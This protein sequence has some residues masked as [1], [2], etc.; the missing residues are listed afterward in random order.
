MIVSKA[1]SALRKGGNPIRGEPG[2]AS[3]LTLTNPDGWGLGSSD[4]VAPS[5]A[6]KLSAVYAAVQYIA[7]FVASL[8]TYVYDRD[9]RQ[10]VPDHPLMQLL[11]MR[12][13][14]A[15]TPSDY[16]RMQTRSLELRGNAYT[17][18]HR[19]P[20]NGLPVELLPL[21]ADHMTVRLI[22]GQLYYFYSHPTSGIVYRLLPCDVLHYKGNSDDGYT[23]I[24]TLQY[25]ARTLRIARSGSQYEEAVYQHG[26]HPS[27]VLQTDA[28]LGGSSLVPDPQNPKRLLS[29]KENVRRAWEDVHAGAANAFRTAVLDNGLKYQPLTVS[30]FDAQFIAA[31]STTV[32]DIAR[33][34]GVPL[35]ALMTGKQSY[36]SNEQNALEFV[37][38]RGLAI[39][40][41]MEEEDSYKLLLEA[42]LRQNLWVRRNVNARLRG[43]TA[44]RASFYTAM[45]TIGGFSVN[46]ILALEDLPDVPGGDVRIARLDGV[47]LEDFRAISLARNMPAADV[48]K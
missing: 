7:D 31:K 41:E 47:P 40:R 32:E 10:R 3:I 30:S 27:G 12:P 26:A 6:L 43:D 14:E 42:D 11:A 28:D 17:Y 35:H 21:Q 9:K 16:K 19:D 20:R 8:P 25:A 18:I 37:Q 4:I 46:D 45:H 24:S 48:N 22:E 34:F 2:Q 36:Q 29:K 44:Q 39:L 33:F 5:E 15:Q 13:N 1:S 38:G 23:G